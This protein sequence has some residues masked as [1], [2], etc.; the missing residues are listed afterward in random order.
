MFDPSWNSAMQ[1]MG[2]GETPP[3]LSDFAVKA[4][5]ADKLDL[6]SLLERCLAARGLCL[7]RSRLHDAVG[8]LTMFLADNSHDA[9]EDAADPE[10]SDDPLHRQ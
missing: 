4:T 3:A 9:E 2:F 10:I 1:R 6:V 7:S 8:V 5:S